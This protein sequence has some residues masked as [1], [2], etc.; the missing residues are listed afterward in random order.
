MSVDAR[1]R[2][3]LFLA[4]QYPVEVPGVSV[5]NFLRTAVTA[6]R[7]EAPKLRVFLKDMRAAMAALS[8][9]PAFA[10]R[11][12]NEGFSGGE[13]KRHEILQLELLKP[14][15][16]DPGRD[17][18]R[19]G[20]RRA[21]GRVRGRQP[22]R[23]RRG[24]RRAADHPLHPDPAVHE[25]GLRARVR[26]RPDRRGGRPRAGRRRWRPRA[27]SGSRRPGPRH[28]PGRARGSARTSR[29]WSGRSAT[30]SRWS[31]WTAPTPRRSR[32]RCSTRSADFYERHN[33]NI[34]RATHE[35]G[36]EATEAYEGARVTV[37]G[38]IG[39]AEPAEV[40]FTKNVSEAINLVAYSMG[41]ASAAAGGA[42]GSRSA[43]A[44]RSSSPRWST[45]PTSCPWQLLCERTG[46]TLRWFRGDAGGPAGHLGHR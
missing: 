38:F 30:A 35:L 10:E 11:N 18:L 23:R 5:S 32:A 28:D 15:D 26:R 13:K 7:G 42:A 29:S 2:A 12:V 1:A 17:R 6:V 3:G 45:T 41:N 25:A 4:M 21:A 9:D 39:A 31:T 14:E 22:V 44:T 20:H 46:A 33:A 16:R 37:A 19:A 27:T 8:I 40:V 24:P 34:H 36:E 43:R